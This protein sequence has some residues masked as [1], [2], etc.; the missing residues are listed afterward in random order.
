MLQSHVPHCVPA[1]AA[2]IFTAA[3]AVCGSDAP[4]AIEGSST[5]YPITAAIIEQWANAGHPKP[6]LGQN[7]S[8]AGIAQLIAGRIPI[9]DSSRCITDAEIARGHAQGVDIIEVPIACDGITVVVNARNTFITELT[10]AELKSAFE[11][12]SA[13]RSWS[14]LRADWPSKPMHFFASGGN[15]GTREFFTKAITHSDM[16]LREDAVTNEDFSVLIQG[17]IADPDAITF[18]G[19]AYYQN[20]ANMLRAVPLDDGK[21]PI[22]PS[23]EAILH[24]GYQPLSRPLFIYVSKQ[25][26]DRPEVK[27]FVDFYFDHVARAADE[28]GYVA[29]TPEMYAL[30]RDR[31]A[32]RVTGSMFVHAPSGVPL[33]RILAGESVPAAMPA[34]ATAAAS[35]APAATAA[36]PAPAPGQARALVESMR[37]RAL[38]L[39]RV[40]MDDGS[41][42]EDLRRAVREAGLAADELDG[43]CSAGGRGRAITLAE[44]SSQGAAR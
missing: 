14:D 7:G 6:S 5:V 10:T 36:A 1:L 44:A 18:C 23:R 30:A 20:N 40:A 31:I 21:G 22:T 2:L 38:R 43:A 9:A 42:L 37:D 33:D 15:S 16:A 27:A 25:M 35:A 39:A 29:L 26:L 41:S 34:P 11:P 19:W 3:G 8:G 12:H 17:V 13:I 24:G 28:V 4:L 32:H